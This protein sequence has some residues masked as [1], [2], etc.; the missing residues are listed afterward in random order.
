[1]YRPNKVE[2][3]PGQE[4]VWDY[5]R[6][7]RVEITKKEIKIIFNKVTIVN[8]SNAKRVL[9]TSHPPVYYI[10]QTDILMQYLF[11]SSGSSFCEWKGEAIY[12][13]LEVNGKR[14]EKVAWSYPKP[15]NRFEVIKDHLAFYA[16]PMDACLVEGELVTPQPGNFYGGWIT[17]DIVGP[18]KGGPGSWG[19]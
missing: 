12:Y 15:T 1:M 7:P 3:K 9:E 8:S 11:I 13:S 2:P 14:L 5:P 16:H 19:W 18:F 10:P 6:P 17:S 4:S